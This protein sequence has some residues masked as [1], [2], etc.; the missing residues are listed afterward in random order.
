VYSKEG[1][2]VRCT[3]C[4]INK[5]ET[6]IRNVKETEMMG[7]FDAKEFETVEYTVS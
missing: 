2:R 7:S 6:N 1:N 3:S 4:I 5:E